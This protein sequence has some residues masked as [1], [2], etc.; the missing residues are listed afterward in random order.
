MRTWFLAGLCAMAAATFVAPGR[1][2]AVDVAANAGFG[3]GRWDYWSTDAH[4]VNTIPDWQLSAAL[5]GQPFR[6]GLLEWQAGASYMGLHDYAPNQSTSRGAWGYRLSSSMLSNSNTP[7]TFAASR[8]TTSFASD[9]TAGQPGSTITQSGTTETN[10]L[11][12]SLVLRGI[13]YPT[14][15]LQGTWVDSTN[16][17]IGGINTSLDTKIVNVGVGQ[18]LGN[19]IYSVD[20]SSTWNN[21]NYTLNNYRSD[22]LNAQFITTPRPDIMLRFREYYIL[23]TPTNNAPLNPRYDDNLVSAGVIYR[24]G[25]RWSSSLDYGYQHALMT[26]MTATGPSNSEQTAHQLSETTNFRYRPNLYFFATGTAATTLEQQQDN[27]VRGGNQNLGAGGN[28]L[29]TRGATTLLT[30]GNSQIAALETGGQPTTLG[31]GVGGGEGVGHRRGRLSMNLSYNISYAS[32]TSG[33]GGSSLSQIVYGNADALVGRSMKWSSTLSYS[34]TRRDDPVLGTFQNHT[35]TFIARTAWQWR[36]NSFSFD[37]TLG[38]T[39]GL[40]GAVALPVAAPSPTI[41]SSSYN[42]QSRFASLQATQSMLRGKLVL[43]EVGRLMELQMPQQQGQHEESAWV[44]LRYT[45]GLMYI[46]AENRLSR[47]GTNGPSQT[48]NLFMLRLS[49]NF[50]AHF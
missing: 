34:Q 25:Q 18:S 23:R 11:S 30:S 27:G 22:Y 6:P 19:H 46:T 9:T 26:A 29:Y 40:S 41:V 3:L 8:T 39:D 36:R 4:T 31:Y 43:V 38:E 50:G 35:L 10:L 16:T 44:S 14:V 17:P 48:S 5:S 20:Y 37:L 47:G 12:S 1:A 45:M 24:P 2:S 28:W 21:G 15:R 32:N 7:A 49:R 13:S 33:V 42:T